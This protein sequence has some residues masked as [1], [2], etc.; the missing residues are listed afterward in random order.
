[1][2]TQK[3][4]QVVKNFF[5]AMENLTSTVA[6]PHLGWRCWRIGH[7]SSLLTAGCQHQAP[8]PAMRRIG[9]EAWVPHL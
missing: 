7:L 4:V 6:T 3:N 1:M 9:V 5:A 2:S 8:Q